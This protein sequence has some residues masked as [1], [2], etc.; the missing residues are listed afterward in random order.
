VKVVLFCGGM[1]LRLREHADALPKPIVPIGD[2]PIVWHVMKYYAHYGHRDFILCLGYKSA[3]IKEYFLRYNEAISNDFVMSEGG[4]RLQLMGADIQDWTITFAETGLH[5]NIGQRLKA[6]ERYVQGEEMFLANYADDLTDFDLSSMIEHFKNSGKIAAF[7]CVQPPHSF[8][9][10]SMGE[11]HSVSGI[12]H[13]SRSGLYINGGYFILRREIFD[14]IRDGEE[15]V[16]EPFRRLIAEGQ[17][18]AYRHDGFWMPMDTF[19]DK[20]LLE[21]MYSRGTG[22]WEVW[23]GNRGSDSSVCQ[24]ITFTVSATDVGE[25][26]V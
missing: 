14:F 6:V 16:E 3:V 1:G 7:L 24:Q 26:V 17:L 15:L 2:R 22:P 4:K 21:D 8:H 12:R 20:Q 13:V 23:K 5:T 10:V 25:Q 18:A 9:V 11:G 19:K